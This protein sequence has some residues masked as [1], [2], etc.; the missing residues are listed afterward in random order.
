[1]CSSPSLIH[2]LLCIKKSNNS[3]IDNLLMQFQVSNDDCLTLF[4]ATCRK[5][6]VKQRIIFSKYWQ[7]LKKITS[8]VRQ[9]TKICI[10]M[11]QVNFYLVRIPIFVATD[12]T[13]TNF[14]RLFEI[15]PKSISISAMRWTRSTNL[16]CE[17]QNSINGEELNRRQNEANAKTI[18]QNVNFIDSSRSVMFS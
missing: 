4:S 9:L 11:R 8:R 18:N 6:N 13:R 10:Y 15:L 3:S 14:M 7:N 12:V 16:T 1:M 2:S 17:C 5:W